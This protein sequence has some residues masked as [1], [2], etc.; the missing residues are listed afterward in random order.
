MVTSSVAALTENASLLAAPRVSREQVVSAILSR[1]HGEYSDYSVHLIVSHYF[2]ICERARLDPLIVLAQMIHETGNLSSWW[3]ARPRRNPAGL[4]VT[5][6]PGAGLSFASWERSSMAHV[7]RL[8]AYALT[9]EQANGEQWGLICIALH[10]RPLPE[11]L[12]GAAPT[13]RGLEG[14]W[15][16]DPQYASK[17]ARTA[18][19][20]IRA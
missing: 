5:G 17:L 1:P 18:N 19:M 20:L 10:V 8:L 16:T 15:A 14:T 12:R 13:L 3:A 7:G 4:G 6:E 9:D 11:H 2:R